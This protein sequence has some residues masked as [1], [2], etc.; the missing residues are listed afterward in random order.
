M[1]DEDLVQV[2][3]TLLTVELPIEVVKAYASRL[4]NSILAKAC[5]RALGEDPIRISPRN[6]V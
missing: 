6:Y 2:T 1:K 5:R 3:D 4:D